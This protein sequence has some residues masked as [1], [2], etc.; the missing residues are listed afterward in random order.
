VNAYGVSLP[1]FAGF[2]GY[3]V[4][5]RSVFVLDRE[6]TIAYKWVA[7]NPGIEPDYREV[8]DKLGELE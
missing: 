5:Q 4:A 7:D 1:D 3:T 6:G 2:T 8:E